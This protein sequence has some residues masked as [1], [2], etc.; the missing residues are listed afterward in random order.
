MTK[1]STKSTGELLTVVIPSKNEG[2]TLYECLYHLQNQTDIEGTKVVVADSSTENESKQWIERAR[3]DFKGRIRIETTEGG[4]PAQ[5][6][7][8]GSLR[9]RTEHVLFMDAD[10]MLHNPNTIAQS[11]RIMREKGYHLLTTTI[12]TDKPYRWVYKAFYLC[13]LLAKHLLG[14][15]FAPGG[16]QLWNTEAYWNTGGWRPDEL[17]AEDYSISKRVEPKRFRVEGIKGV[18]TSARRFRNKGVTYMLKLMVKSYLHRN[19]PGFFKN[20][21]GYWD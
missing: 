3:K 20:S 21:H 7:L 18:Y 13:Q 10:T 17:F 8:T 15:S 9:V 14:T 12:E 11:I 5:A 4:Y 1:E 2:D 19:D 6:R 16:Y